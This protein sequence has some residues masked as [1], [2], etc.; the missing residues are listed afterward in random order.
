MVTIGV[1]P[2]FDPSRGSFTAFVERIQFYF[3]TNSVAECGGA[4]SVPLG[5]QQRG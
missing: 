3:A 4:R 5:G 1:L 2:E